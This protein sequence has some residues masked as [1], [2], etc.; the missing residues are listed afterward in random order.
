MALPLLPPAPLPG[1]AIA[2]LTLDKAEGTPFASHFRNQIRIFAMLVFGLMAGAAAMALL[3][4]GPIGM[5]AAA[6][7]FVWRA[8]DGM[9][10]SLDG[11]PH[12]KDDA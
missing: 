6:M 1:L 8:L 2:L 3:G 9:L 11:K 10:K 5:V 7:W 4:I 12:P